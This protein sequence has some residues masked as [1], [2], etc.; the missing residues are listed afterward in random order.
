MLH[1]DISAVLKGESE[2]CVI[3][4]DCLEIM[5]DMPG[6]CVDAV[7]TD[8]PYGMS[9]HSGRYKNG[10]PHKPIEN[11]LK[12]PLAALAEFR[13][14][15]L[16]CVYSFCRWDNLAEV[17][18]PGS[19]IAWV[20]NNWTAGDLYHA[21]GR[22]WEGCLFYPGPEH[23]F[24]KRPA[25]IIFCDRIPHGKLKHPTEKPIE[26][27]E[28]IIESSAG[29]IVV[30]PYCGAGGTCVAA[31]KLGRRW[32]GI[33]ISRAYVDIAKRRLIST[34]R[35]LFPSQSE[36]DSTSNSRESLLL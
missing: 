19:F 8:P 6:G 31:K 13:R 29:D 14:I 7:V 16:C 11:D 5:R 10:N 1:K 12:Y 2:G 36:K 21:H 20:K 35:P 24:I 23:R 28:K 34:P 26:L 3:C 30:G 18:K 17:P 27:F 9:Y 25:D 15:A 32:I 33:D 22:Q 4:G